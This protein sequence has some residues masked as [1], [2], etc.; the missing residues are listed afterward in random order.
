MQL[1]VCI[2]HI[3]TTKVRGCSA[4]DGVFAVEVTACVL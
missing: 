4:P 2:E 3:D 1:T